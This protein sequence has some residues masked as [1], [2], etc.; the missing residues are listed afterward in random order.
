MQS[1]LPRTRSGAFTLIEL[2][3]VIAIIAVLAAI[4]FPV[5]GNMKNR[6]NQSASVNNLRQWGA[7][8]AASLAEFDGA[9][10]SDG[11][12]G[13]GANLADED[14]WFNRLPKF[15][16]QLALNNPQV[17]TNPPSAGQKSL[18]VNPG[19]NTGTP[20][21]NN[22]PFFYGMNDFLSN[23]D[24]PTMKMLRVERPSATVFMAEKLDPG[25]AV[26]LQQVQ[27]FFGGGN[28]MIDQ[29]NEAN[30][31]FCDGHVATMKRRIFMN[32]LSTQVNPIDPSYTW[33]PFPEARQQ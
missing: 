7:A 4:L 19:V 12:T 3:T 23:A 1:P 33:M 30:F 15:M 22:R 28:P 21:A 5:I 25:S 26:T 14:A 6:A 17:Q 9:M 29:D 13:G 18:F 2:L 8:L 10:P 16:G 20:G 32:P 27:A 11:A 31:V 24:E